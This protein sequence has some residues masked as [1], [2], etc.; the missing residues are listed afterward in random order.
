MVAVA[1]DTTRHVLRKHRGLRRAGSQRRAHSREHWLHRIEAPS[2]LNAV[3]GIVDEMQ[4]IA[5][6]HL[7]GLPEHE[8]RVTLFKY[9]GWRWT[10]RSKPWGGWLVAFE[11]SGET[12][13]SH[14]SAFRVS[15]S[16]P[17]EAEG[18]AGRAFATGGVVPTGLLPEVTVNSSPEV[19][20]EYG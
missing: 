19:I 18:V 8:R 14:V 15:L 9:V 3:H 17:E 4:R 13:R 11:R 5:F 2:V 10:L 20:A 6:S 1:S 16:T 12:T 7:E